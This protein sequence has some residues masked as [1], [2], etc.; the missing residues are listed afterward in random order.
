MHNRV[1]NLQDSQ[2][3]RHRHSQRLRPLLSRAVAPAHNHH[4][5]RLFSPALDPPV[6]PLGLPLRSRHRHRALSHLVN[7][8]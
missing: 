7:Q 4:R 1:L 6:S 2:V 8:P 3:F 5:G